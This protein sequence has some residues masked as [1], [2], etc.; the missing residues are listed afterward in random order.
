MLGEELDRTLNALT[1]EAVGP[2]WDME[3][4]EVAAQE[5]I[6]QGEGGYV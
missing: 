3:A 5:A 4:L 6:A 1:K 2:Q